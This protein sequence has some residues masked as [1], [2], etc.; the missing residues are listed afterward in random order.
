MKAKKPHVFKYDRRQ[1]NA[2]LHALYVKTAIKHI[3]AIDQAIYNFDRF[4]NLNLND[5]LLAMWQNRTK[6]TIENSAYA[7]AAE[8]LNELA[9]LKLVNKLG[10]LFIGYNPDLES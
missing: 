3:L 6:L 2:A 7:E 5:M 1:D 10:N 4:S 8:V 9:G